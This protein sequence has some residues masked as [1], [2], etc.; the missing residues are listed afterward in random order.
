MT[1]AAGPCLPGRAFL[2]RPHPSASSFLLERPFPLLGT[3]SSALAL[4]WVG[5]GDTKVHT[6][7]L[8]LLGGLTMAN[9]DGSSKKVPGEASRTRGL[10]N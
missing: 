8:S 7:T 2:L 10:L 5:A 3:G 1:A 4:R 6:E 9:Q